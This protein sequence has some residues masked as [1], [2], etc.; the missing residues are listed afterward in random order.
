MPLSL[1]TKEKIIRVCQ[2]KISQ[3]GEAVGLSFYAF[4]ENKNT[5][6]QLL[7][8]VATWWIMEENLD[9]F[10]KAI[11]IKNLVEKLN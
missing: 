11:K 9:H 6:P 3:K 10:E 5:D 1:A 7:L 8:D 4:F 2:S